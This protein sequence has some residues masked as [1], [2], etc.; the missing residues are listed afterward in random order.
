MF[1]YSNNFLVE[2]TGPRRSFKKY[3]ELDYDLDSDGEW[4]EV[5]SYTSNEFGA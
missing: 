3:S 5:L 4:K 2:I 1:T